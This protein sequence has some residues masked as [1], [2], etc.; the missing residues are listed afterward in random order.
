MNHETNQPSVES[1]DWRWR[2][3]QAEAKVK[4]LEEALEQYDGLVEQAR[5]GIYQV[6]ENAKSLAKN[7]TRLLRRCYEV[8]KQSDFGYTLDPNPAVR[9]R[10]IEERTQTKRDLIHALEIFLKTMEEKERKQDE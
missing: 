9:K 8:L 5:V 7:T 4:N 1:W 10:Q 2:A 3:E 6:Q